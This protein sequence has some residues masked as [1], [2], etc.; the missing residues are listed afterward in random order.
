MLPPGE[1]FV[2]VDVQIV[3]VLPDHVV[4]V[5]ERM[6]PAPACSGGEVLPP[7]VVRQVLR[8]RLADRSRLQLAERGAATDL[9]SA[10]QSTK[11]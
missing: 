10:L 6:G 1:R 4:F 2:Q 7:A 9:F 5:P 8:G 3:R 11:E